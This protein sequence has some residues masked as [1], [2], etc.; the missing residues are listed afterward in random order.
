M[1][2]RIVISIICACGFAGTAAAQAWNAE[3]K[4]TWNLEEQQ[5]KMAAAEDLSWID[6]MR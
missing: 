1:F 2:S 4:E 3:Q 5:W 6:T